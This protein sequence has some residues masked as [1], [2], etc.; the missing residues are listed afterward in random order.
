VAV[1]VVVFG[2]ANSLL[3]R[4]PD[5]YY[6]TD[7]CKIQPEVYA[8]IVDAGSWLARVDRTHKQIRTWFDE[9]ERIDVG[10]GC[11]VGMG[12]VASSITQMVFVPYVTTPFPMPGIAEVPDTAIR[13]LESSRLVLA[14][15]SSRTDTLDRWRQRINAMGLLAEEVTTHRVPLLESAFTIHAWRIAQQ[16][17][18]NVSFGPSI[19]TIDRATTREVNA[20]GTPK[21]RLSAAGDRWQ[22]QPTDA[23][24]HVAYPFATLP[25]GASDSWARVIVEST[26][27]ADSSCQLIVQAQDFT[28]LGRFDCSSGTRYAR[29]P[30]TARRLRVYLAD[31]KQQ[32]FALPTKIDVALSVSEP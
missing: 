7:P 11:T 17:P 32:P 24:D 16:T 20:Y 29:V 13:S 9:Q 23:R 18:T 4:G 6:A 1:F 19:M 10:R 26:Q 8:A 15:I 14:L 3:A 12:P 28:V 25:P 31:P 2:F 22:F 30:S 5:R 27:A 21:G